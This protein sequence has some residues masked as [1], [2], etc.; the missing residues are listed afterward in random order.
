MAGGALCGLLFFLSA[1]SLRRAD[2]VAA[3]GEATRRVR[4]RVRCSR[5]ALVARR[6]LQ[7]AAAAVAAESEEVTRGELDREAGERHDGSGCSDRVGG[8]GHGGGGGH[9]GAGGAGG[10]VSAGGDGGSHG[11]GEGGATG[12]GGDVDDAG[13]VWVDAVAYTAR[14]EQE[15]DGWR[16]QATG[17]E[18][19]SLLYL[20]TVWR[21]MRQAAEPAILAPFE[22]R[23]A[24]S[25]EVLDTWQ[26]PAWLGAP[27][28]GGGGYSFVRA[29]LEALLVEVGMAIEPPWEG[30]STVRAVATKL[31]A[32]GVHTSAELL[33]ALRGVEAVASDEASEGGLT[34]ARGHDGGAALNRRL[35]AHGQSAFRQRSIDAM[36][37]LLQL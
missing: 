13:S 17:G 34:A 28:A 20:C 25:L 29:P 36:C 15:G 2:R 16:R 37:E 30:E 7:A 21:A 1:P 18:R 9:S 11:G 3:E 12:A 22:V 35:R 27:A 32:C 19:P 23:S 10:V 8:G 31:Q 5:A 26:H 4:V 14:T 33:A 24:R 6:D